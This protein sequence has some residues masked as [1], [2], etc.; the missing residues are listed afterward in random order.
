MS[1]RKN[2]ETVYSINKP[3][4]LSDKK[5]TIE[6]TCDYCGKVFIPQRNTQKYCCIE[7]SNAA[8]SEFYLFGE[9]SI[10]LSKE[11][12][13][14]AADSCT[15]MQELANKLNTSRP[16]IRKYLDKYGILDAFKEKF[17]FRAKPVCQYDM[18]KNFLRE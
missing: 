13:L 4:L 5:K 12:F 10:N 6:K 3:S 1:I 2:P 18:H 16:T 8:K 11:D 9:N 17:D 15:T 14:K 7:C